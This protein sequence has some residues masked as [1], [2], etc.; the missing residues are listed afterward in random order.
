M[1]TVQASTYDYPATVTP[2]DTVDDPAGTFTGLYVITSGTLK[3][4]PYNGPQAGSSITIA[5]IAGTYLCWPVK[6][7]WSSTTSATV[8]GLVS[9][10]VRQGA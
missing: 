1:S 9:P 10:V 7:V 8:L 5:V 2:S 4:T 3:F 6:R